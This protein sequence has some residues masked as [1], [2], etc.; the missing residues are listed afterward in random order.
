VKKIVL[1]LVFVFSMFLIAKDVDFTIFTATQGLSV[2]EVQQSA[3]MENAVNVKTPGYKEVKVV[4]YSDPGTGRILAKKTNVFKSGGLYETNRALDAAIEGKGFFVL[5]DRTGR[6]F[7]TRDGR[8]QV[9]I[10]LEVVSLSGGLYLLDENNSV[11]EIP[12]SSGKIEI[13]DKGYMYS[14]EGD[15]IARM[16]IA[17]VFDYSKL[18]SF[19]NVVFYLNSID[20]GQMYVP[21]SYAIKQGF[22]EASNVNYNK[23]MVQMADKNV[24]NANTQIIQTRLKMMDSVNGLVNQN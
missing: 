23:L 20:E 6:M 1:L 15:V 22:Y 2:L 9:N 5:A 3:L 24:Y 16:K 7:F 19:N 10:N 18:R 21:D 4:S 14:D 8:F 13:D 11:I 12:E 17:N